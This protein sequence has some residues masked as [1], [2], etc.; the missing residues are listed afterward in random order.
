MTFLYRLFDAHGDLLYIG[1]AENWANRRAN[2]VSCKPWWPEVADGRVERI[3]PRPEA[4]EIERQAIWNERPR[5]NVTHT[6]DKPPRAH[7]PRSTLTPGAKQL[8]LRA[9]ADGQPVEEVRAM[10]ADLIESRRCSHC[11]TGMVK[12]RGLCQTC[13]AHRR[14]YGTDRPL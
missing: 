5:Y 13:Y 9:K 4:L 12:C 8:I 11:W 14:R 7:V 1:I 3:P 10:L 2:H 6:G